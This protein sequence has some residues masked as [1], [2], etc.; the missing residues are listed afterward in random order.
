MGRR[1]KTSALPAERIAQINREL[2]KLASKELPE[3]AWL[4]KLVVKALTERMRTFHQKDY[5]HVLNCLAAI[6]TCDALTDVDMSREQRAELIQETL[7]DLAYKPAPRIEHGPGVIQIQREQLNEYLTAEKFPVGDGARCLL[8]IK[9]RW[10]VIMDFLVAIPCGCVYQTSHD[11]F[12]ITEQK[13]SR[14]TTIAKAADLILSSLH[15]TLDPESIRKYAR[16]HRS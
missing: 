16:T 5:R 9:Q 13:Y 10:P 8:W 7:K 3:D 4:L 12:L 2:V 11:E 6:T 14:P 15:K 1:P